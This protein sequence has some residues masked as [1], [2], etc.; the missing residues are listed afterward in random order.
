MWSLRTVKSV[1][2]ASGLSLLGPGP[3]IATTLHRLP[4]R[5]FS[6]DSLDKL[7]NIG[8]SAHI[9]SGKTTLTER[10]LFYSGRIHAIHDV[11]GKDDKGAKMDHMELEKE[12]GITITSAATFTE[13]RDS[14]I[15]IIDTPGHVDFTIEVERS[16]RVLDGAILVLCGVAGVQSQS[17]T[18]DKQMKRYNVPRIVFI[19]KLDRSAADPQKA[20][21]TLREILRM[22]CAFVQLPIGL[23]HLFEG[24]V[25]I[26]EMKSYRFDGPNG[27]TIIE[28]EVPKDMQ[29]DADAKRTELI[30]MVAEVDDELAEAYLEEEV[31]TEL[32][33]AAIRRATIA[34]KF[35]P[36]FM[37]SA[38]KN[39]AV[40][41][42]LDGVVDYLPN[43][44]QVENIAL[45]MDQDEKPMVLDTNSS[46]PFV[47]LAFKLEETKFGQ[48]TYMRVYQG[49]LKR[50]MSIYNT[51]TN[52]MHKVPRLVR[53][54]SNEM[55]DVESVGAGEICAL[56]GVEC[57]SGTTFTAKKENKLTMSSMH[58]PE[59]VISLAIKPKDATKASGPFSKGLSRFL[60]E[61]PTFRLTY[62]PDTKETIMS[63][64]GELHLEV[65]TERLSREYGVETITG[66]PQVNYQET[67]TTKAP[68]E[69]THKKQSGG[70]GQYAKVIGYLEP[71]PADSNKK[72]EFVNKLKGNNIPPE[73]LPAIQKGFE[74]AAEDGVAVGCNVVGVRFVIED[75][76]SHAVDSSE[77]AFRIATVKA[78]Q[79]AFKKSAFEV[80]EPV[81]K[82]EAE[83]P[84]KFQSTVV[85][86]L[87]RRRAMI[88]DVV[89]SDGFT[90]VTCRVPLK[91]MFG[92]STDLRS[93]T[94]GKGEY[95]MEYESHAAVGSVEQ[96]ELMVEYEKRRKMKESE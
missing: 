4:A 61:D 36:V 56:Y 35:S 43:P 70:A 62:D 83:T 22:N 45:D 27:E 19:N 90:K 16:L 95:S 46:K 74:K 79:Q 86:G 78:F 52:K 47:G 87:N 64:M 84:D 54:H 77:L 68:F 96:E 12:K 25:D 42:L 20:M 15:N 94:E 37:G 85:A 5:L 72:L 39:K 11:K 66:A 44:K 14:H 21:G 57:D 59:P 13:W 1:S 88:D 53:M 67:I 33:K 89:T 49:T 29:D 40:Q 34:L 93:G 76:Q 7:R 28:G 55:E 80:H 50:T 71:L 32:L 81:M 75:G 24:V 3:A 51:K 73:Y 69:Y 9:D 6:S 63:G 23:E 92:Y 8:I 10:I 82:V 91:Q 17:M 26:V 58:V 60:R 2:R 65:Y 48:I 18:V 30:E 41:P 38:F 31:T